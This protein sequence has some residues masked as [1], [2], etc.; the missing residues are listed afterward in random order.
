MGRPK[1]NR[2]MIQVRVAPDTPEKLKKI[3]LE[4]GYQWGAEGNTGKLLD[5]IASLEVEELKR[6]IESKQ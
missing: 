1:L 2:T 6:L 4:L 5:A 3:A